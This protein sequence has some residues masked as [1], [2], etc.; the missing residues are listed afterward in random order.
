MP[1][2]DGL[3]C[4]KKIVSVFHEAV[5]CVLL[6]QSF[7]VSHGEQSELIC[8]HQP[9]I[10]LAG[11]DVILP[12]Y[13]EPPIDSSSETVTWTRPGLDPKYI[14]VYRD[15]QPVNRSQNPSYTNRTALFED[16]LMNGNISLKLSRVKI[17]DGGKYFC[18][19]EPMMKEASI[20]LTVG[21]VSTPIIEDVSNNSRRVVLQ[22]E[23]KGWY[24]EPEVVWLDG[25][26]NLLSAGPTE[27]VRGPDD[28]YTVSSRVTVEKRHSNNFTCRVQQKDINQTRET[29]IYVPVS[30]GE[31]SELICS[32]QPI[33]ALAGDDVI[34]PCHLEPPISASSETVVWIKP[35]LD[36][37]YIHVHQDGQP[38]NQSQNP[39][40]TNRTALF[41]DE[42][43]NGNVSLK[44]SR[45]KISDGGKYRCFLQPMRKK[46]SL[47]LTVG[48]V[49]TPIIEIVSNNSRRVVLQ[50]ESKGWYPE[51]E[52]VWLDGEGN[53]LSAGPTETVRGPDDLYTV[54][55]RVTVEKRHSNNFTCRVQQKDINQTRE[56]HIYVPVSH[57]EQSELICSHQPIVALAGDDVIFQCRLEPPISA[58]SETVV[59]IKPGLD[60][61]YIHVHQDGQPVNQS[62]NPSYTNRTALFE[63]D[64][65]NGNVSLKLS[66]VEIS[67]GGKYR[68]FLQPM[69]KKASVYLTVGVV[70]TPIIEVVSNKSRKVV[71]QC[72]SNSW[73]PEPEVVWLDG[74]G[75]LL[76]A[77]PTETVRGPDDLYT[78]SSR[79]TV[80][81]R[82]SNNNVTCGVQQKDINQT[83]ETHIYVPG[84]VSIPIIKVVS[85][86]SGRVV[87]Q[88]ESKGWYTQPEVVWL[89][90]EG[91]LLSAEPTETVR[92]PDD[93]YTVSSRMDVEKR[94]S[95]HLTCRVHHK[96][97]NKTI[98]TNIHVPGFVDK[99]SELISSH[100]PIVALAGDDV[101]LPCYLKPPIDASSQRVTWTRPGLDPKYINVYRDRR[102]VCG[103][104]KAS[105]TNRTALF[106]DELKNG[107]ISLKL[108]RVKISDG[109]KYFCILE[110]LV[111]KASINLT[112]GVVSTPIIEDVSN[113]SRKVVLQCESKGWY[114]EPEVVWLDGEGNLLSAGPTETVR[115][116]DDL[117]TVSSRVTVEKRHSNNFT[118]RVQQ[119]DIN[120]TR[121]THIY[122]PALV[123]SS[124]YWIWI[125]PGVLLLVLLVI[126]ISLIKCVRRNREDERQRIIQPPM[127]MHLLQQ[128]R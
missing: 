19:L 57:E 112:V 9:I 116:P 16:E 4:F 60:P 113:K 44:L 34:F 63:D 117:Y 33:V 12:C 65:M 28:L 111:K 3:M 20:N 48:V 58:S 107:N 71:L 54:S 14:H 23:S 18:I 26:G 46:A 68:C 122:V 93:L 86:D 89:D 80:V 25:E 6:L 83:R 42:L 114:P 85:N 43:K 77:G 2:N 92:G 24:P 102:P 97:I 32:H 101:I 94:H 124:S 41:E 1:S 67:D 22:C 95:K 13:L 38:V 74:E 119:K 56:T 76:S 121:E 87:L 82:H 96:D 64:L 70:S 88:C 115:G 104:Q 31:Q 62:Q 75:N 59:W 27:T 8:S 98:E 45:V 55:S 7:G 72:E 49:S 61:K 79:V 110:P 69:R 105:C 47:H 127:L 128:G 30:H 73:Y 125:I 90:G 10:A 36:P 39:S 103:R 15:G 78:A 91:N 108:F 66:R 84:V 17:S 5:I 99:Q 52:V 51:P 106:V 126:T 50:C 53:L 29:Y 109:G 118:C 123:Q 100:Q 40:Y 120:Q 37:K 21:A 81:K 35:G 11:N